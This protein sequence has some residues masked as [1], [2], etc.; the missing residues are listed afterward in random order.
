MPRNIKKL[1]TLL[2]LVA[3]V[4]SCLLLT[5]ACK[6]NKAPVFSSDKLVFEDNF[7][8]DTLDMTKWKF[9]SHEDFK[10]RG[11]YYD[12]ENIIVKDGNLIIRTDYKDGKY[13][14]GWYTGWIETSVEKHPEDAADGY[15]G[16]STTYGYFEVRCRAANMT[17]AWS[18][19]WMMP[20]E[21]VAFTDDD[22]QDTGTD[23][24]E[25]DIM[26]TNWGK[27]RTGHV[28]HYDGYDEKLKSV[29]SGKKRVKNMHTEFHTFALEWTES[30]YIFYIDGEE[31]WRTSK[32]GTSRV[33][34]YM[35][36][37]HEVGGYFSGNTL[38]PGI[39]EDGTTHWTGDVEMNDRNVSYD[40]VI[41][42]VRVYSL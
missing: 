2:L 40:F 8:G 32:M 25:L 38:H 26:E 29:N 17:G 37:S 9:Y 10:R 33:N 3:V 36:L 7:D 27:N 28:V 13:G 11:C 35:I 34:Q 4:S 41:D 5:T 24:A 22:V 6:K 21:G 18:A 12:T 31:S 30:E 15:Q 14:N 1:F 19:F 39:N 20:D 42:Y 23:G 16:F